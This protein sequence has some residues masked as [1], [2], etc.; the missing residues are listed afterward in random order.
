MPVAAGRSN[1]SRPAAIAFFH[2]S[3]RP[4]PLPCT[5]GSPSS[6]RMVAPRSCRSWPSA[7]PSAFRISG[8]RE[9][10]RSDRS[11][12]TDPSDPS[13]SPVPPAAGPPAVRCNLRPPRTA[14]QPRQGFPNAKGCVWEPNLLV[15]EEVRLVDQ[16]DQRVGAH[17]RIGV[18]Q[19]RRIERPALPI[20]QIGQICTIWSTRRDLGS[21]N[22]S[23]NHHVAS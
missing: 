12:P 21:R 14:P 6:P 1:S 9:F 16:T 13:F 5:G 17:G 7:G 4:A 23:Q 8:R 2:S 10:D 18:L 19:P 22:F 11:D 15:E 3:V 20:R